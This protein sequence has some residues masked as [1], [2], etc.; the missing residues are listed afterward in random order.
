[1]MFAI[2][3]TDSDLFQNFRSYFEIY[4]ETNIEYIELG[5]LKNKI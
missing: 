4:Y 3:I 1:M 5:Y 2:Q